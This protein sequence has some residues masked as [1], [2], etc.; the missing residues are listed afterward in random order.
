MLNLE[1]K[2]YPL[3]STFD[4]ENNTGIFKSA[5]HLDKIFQVVDR[6]NSFLTQPKNKKFYIMSTAKKQNGYFLEILFHGLNFNAKRVKLYR[7]KYFVDVHK[8]EVFICDEKASNEF[9]SRVHKRRLIFF[10]YNKHLLS[11]ISRKIKEFRLP[12]VYTGKGLLSR[13]DQFKTKPGKIR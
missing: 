7:P 13:D 4:K 11:N 10:S 3:I 2:K 1:L 5:V 9:K 12:D 8:S 6:K